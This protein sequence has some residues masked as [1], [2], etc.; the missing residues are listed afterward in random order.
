MSKILK[1]TMILT[2]ATFLSKFLGMIYT[3]P[4]EQM[5]GANGIALYFYAY[6]PYNILL[7]LSTLGVPMAVSKFVSKYNSLEDYQTGRDMFKSGMQLMAFTGVV[8]FLLLFFSA[9]QIAIH[10]LSLNEDSVTSVADVTMVIKMVSFALLIIPCMSIIRGFFQGNESMAPTGISQVIEQIVRIIFLLI[11]VYVVL[12]IVDGTRATAIGFATFAAFIGAVA[13]LLVLA[14]FWKKRKPHLDKLVDQQEYT[15]DLSKKSM[16]KELLGYAGPFVLVGIATPLYQLIDQFTFNQAMSAAGLSEISN[17]SI[18]AIHVLSH[19]LVIIP[20]TLGI[21]LSLAML[22]AITRSFT[23]E[24]M[25]QLN[26]QINQ[27]L[28]IISLLILPAVVGLSVLAYEAY[29][30]FYGLEKLSYRGSLLRWYAPVGLFFALYTVTS[31]ILQGIN[32]QN[33]AVISLGSGLAIK[34]LTNSWFIVEF[35]AKGSIIS[36]GLAVLVAVSLNLWRI[37]RAI[38]FSFKQVYKRTLLI[39]IISTIMAAVVFVIKWS[40]GLLWNPMDSRLAA[41]FILV[42]GV[43]VGGILYM[44]M[45]YKTTLLERILGGRVRILDKFLHRRQRG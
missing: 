2:G 16:M 42:L 19:K 29:G 13:S 26:H 28:Q 4:F 6:T 18:S 9:E 34:L 40:I 8:A 37:H 45:A 23:G 15:Y 32:R 10:S 33:F 21:G 11:S 5:V 1:G 20:V 44:W 35:G 22:P 30:S 17:D 41:F 12:N 36:T 31:S 39:L 43:S 3:V 25:D 7:S 14:V 27:A 24:H 38:D